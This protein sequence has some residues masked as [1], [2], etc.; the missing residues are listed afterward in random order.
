MPPFVDNVD[1]FDRWSFVHASAGLILGL[2]D[3]PRALAYILIVLTELVERVLERLGLLGIESRGNV[4][5]DILLGVGAYELA[6]GFSPPAA[7]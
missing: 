7:L 2:L 6:R 1:P 4:L 3:V 5:V